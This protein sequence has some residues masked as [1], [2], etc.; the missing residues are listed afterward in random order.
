MFTIQN[1]KPMKRKLI[2]ALSLLILVTCQ[3]QKDD[4]ADPEDF[5]YSV[6]GK[7]DVSELGVS[8]THEHVMSRFGLDPVYIAEYDKESLF[9]QVIPYL[10]EVKALGVD[11]IFDCTAAYFGRNVSLLKEISDSTGVEIITNTGFYGAAS[12]K[13]VP[14][15]AIESSSEAI[16]SGWIDEFENG[17]NGTGIKPGFIKL[18]F[19][20]GASELDLKLF[21]AGI[22]THLS[23]GLTMAVHTEKNLTGVE[24]QLMLLEEYEVSPSAWVWV[25]ASKVSDTDILIET[26][27]KGGWISLDKFKAG[28]AEAYVSRIKLFREQDVLDKVLISHDGNSYNRDGGLRGYQA[29]MTHLVP[30]LKE[31]GFSDEEINQVMVINP[32]NAFKVGIRKVN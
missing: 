27:K 16:A 19:D 1:T 8:L 2:F 13:Y 7:M 29:V 9:A 15:S 6:H 21:T 24:K 14:E 17:I 28:E 4:S 32:R 12:D 23:T 25:H 31:A 3:C 26:A 30:A 11:T 20:N 5:I 10:K 18:A 22:L